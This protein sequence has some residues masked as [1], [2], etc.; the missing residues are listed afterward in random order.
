MKSRRLP[1]LPWAFFKESPRGQVCLAGLQGGACMQS[2]SRARVLKA[3]LNLFLGSSSFQTPCFLQDLFNLPSWSLEAL[4]KCKPKT[5]S[6]AVETLYNPP[7][8]PLFWS[9]VEA[10]FQFPSNSLRS[11]F[12]WNLL[13]DHRSS[14]PPKPQGWL[15]RALWNSKFRSV[16]F[17]GTWPL[18]EA[19]ERWGRRGTRKKGRRTLK[20]PSRALMTMLQGVFAKG[21]DGNIKG[22]RRIHRS[23]QKCFWK[24]PKSPQ[25]SSKISSATLQI[26][27]SRFALRVASWRVGR[28]VTASLVFLDVSSTSGFAGGSKAKISLECF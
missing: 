8:S 22:A 18:P 23:T 9:F 24:A 7:G 25:L 11:S 13:Q 17:E 16:L 2:F 26:Q 6:R 21:F 5:P 14:P 15:W 3:F 20:E 4:F 10:P 1:R 12:V 27:F 19:K 28:S